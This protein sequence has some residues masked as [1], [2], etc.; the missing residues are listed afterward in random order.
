MPEKDPLS[1]SALTYLWILFLSS[2]GGIVSFNTKRRNGHVRPFN[3]MEL[4]GE[5]ATSAFVGVITFYL[6]ESASIQP[7]VSAALVGIA[8][9]MGSRAVWH[10]EKWAERRVSAFTGEK[11][12]DE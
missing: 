5:M 4:F 11:I 6:C 1:Y 7:L 8:G 2:W 9:H 10:L 3:I 12:G